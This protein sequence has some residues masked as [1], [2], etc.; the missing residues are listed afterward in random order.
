MQSNTDFY[1]KR[2]CPSCRRVVCMYGAS[3]CQICAPKKSWKPNGSQSDTPT[4][5]EV[6]TDLEVN[7]FQ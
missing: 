2:S 6:M 3:K 7:G 1:D 4:T 5:K